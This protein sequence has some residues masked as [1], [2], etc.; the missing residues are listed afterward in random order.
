MS[1]ET[2]KSRFLSVDS[3]TSDGESKKGKKPLTI[4]AQSS[5]LTPKKTKIADKLLTTTADSLKQSFLPQSAQRKAP[6][7]TTLSLST[8]EEDNNVVQQRQQPIVRPTIRRRDPRMLSLETS[9]DGEI[10][11]SKPR[12]TAPN[13]QRGGQNTNQQHTPSSFPTRQKKDPM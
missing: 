13:P 1:S 5:R 7:R 2:R 10:I 6:K 11:L 3:D 4:S 12:T 8:D 9:S